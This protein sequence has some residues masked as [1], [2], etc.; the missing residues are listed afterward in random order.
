MGTTET[1]CKGLGDATERLRS[2]AHNGEPRNR[3]SESHSPSEAK[4][5]RCPPDNT[6][7][8]AHPRASRSKGSH[9]G[10]RAS[11]D[12][13]QKRSGSR[14]RRD[15]SH[16]SGKSFPAFQPTSSHTV[17]PA[18]RGKTF[19]SRSNFKHLPLMNSLSFSFACHA[20]YQS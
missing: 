7:Q 17:I 2:D 19:L 4:D 11:V 18:G 3:E 14:G 12:Q 5:P 15:T 6:S 9:Q 8:P 10:R 20:A 13:Q 16:S 1:G